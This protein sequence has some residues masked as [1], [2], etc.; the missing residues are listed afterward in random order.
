MSEFIS[1]TGRVQAWIDD[2]TGRLPVSCTVMNVE[3]ELEGP[4][5]IE[6]SWRFASHALRRGAGVAIHLSE[7]DP[8]GYERDSGVIA[9][10]P[11]SFGRIYSTLN[12]TL[13]RGGKYKNGAIVLHLDANHKD[14][15][16]FIETPRE[17]LPWAKRCVNITDEW[18]DEM[19]IVVRQKLIKGIKAGDIWLM[20]VFYEGTKRIRGNVC[21]EVL[22][23][24]RGTCLLQHI[25][26]GAC[27]FDDISRAYVEGMQELCSLH[28]RTGVGSTGEYLDPSVDRQVGLG[29]LGLANLLRRY[30]ITYEQFGRAIEHYLGNS[31]KAT[32]AYTLVEKIDEGINEASKIARQH[33]MVRAFAIAPTAS[34]SYRSRDL[35]GFTCTPEIAPPIGRTVDRD[36]GTFGV[37]TFNYG[38]VEIASE[39]GW[40]NYK[41][42][43]DG[44]MQLY[45][46]SGL[47]HG[48][49]FNWWSD[50]TEMNDDF[51]E[52]WLK[53]PQT[54]LYYSLQVMGD[55]QDKTNAYAALADVDVDDY[56]DSII[57]DEPQCDCQE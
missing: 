19:D 47:L 45:K 8:R 33:N 22:L 17:V 31:P 52:E 40:D 49:S 44:M 15:E 2:P 53:S 12:E 30:G 41:R 21:L 55:V 39:V 18:W 42:V 23:P 11:V 1:R 14:I 46:R 16:E 7:L 43:A 13:R 32:A 38:D 29:V 24:S 28:A 37:E 36:S 4:N 3:N 51:I 10:G 25:N 5:G 6:A 35:D 48:Y 57:N 26:L 27:S 50:M 9:S 56:L 54:S 34:C 20:K